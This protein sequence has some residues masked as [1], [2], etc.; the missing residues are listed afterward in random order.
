MPTPPT[1]IKQCFTLKQCK[2]LNLDSVPKCNQCYSDHTFF[3]DFSLE[4]TEKAL[5]LKKKVEKC[6]KKMFRP[7]FRCCK[8]LKACQNTQHMFTVT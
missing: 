3:V 7:A 5:K 8:Y 4:I 2:C 1:V 6:L